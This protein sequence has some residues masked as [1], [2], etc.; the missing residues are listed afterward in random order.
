MI[1]ELINSNLV[2]HTSLG[3]M[4]ERVNELVIDASPFHTSF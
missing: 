3:L 4:T 2:D 1:F